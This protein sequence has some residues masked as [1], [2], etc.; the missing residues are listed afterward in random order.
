MIKYNWHEE[1]S[2]SFGIV[3]RPVAEIHILDKNNQ[4]IS[5]PLAARVP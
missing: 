4:A 3:K 5:P 1:S 2:E